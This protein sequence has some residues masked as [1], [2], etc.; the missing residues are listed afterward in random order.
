MTSGAGSLGDI[1]MLELF[2]AE[3]ETHAACL[4]TG[5][6][7][8]EGTGQVPELITEMMRSA[9]SI[10][11]AA[12]IVGIDAAVR[13]A[14]AMED[15]FV[16]VGQGQTTLKRQGIDILLECVDLLKQL[17]QS[18]PQAPSSHGPSIDRLTSALRALLQEAPASAPLAPAEVS[19]QAAPVPAAPRPPAHHAN[20]DEKQRVVR[21]S[22]GH[23]E[24]LTSL[25]GESLVQTR[26]LRSFADSLLSLQLERHQLAATLAHLQENLADRCD[27]SSTQ[28]LDQAQQ[29]TARLGERMAQQVQDFDLAQRRLSSTTE[30]LYREALASR[31]RPFSDGVQG[32]PRMVRDLAHSL[33]KEV[34]LEILGQRTPV[35]RD[36]LDRLE[37]PLTH[38][39][40]NA[41][42]H[43]LEPTAER[44]SE[45]K[46]TKGKIRLE[47]RHIGGVLSIVISDDGRGIDLAEVRRRIKAKGLADQAMIDRMT[48]GELIEFLFLPGFST[49]DQVTELSGRGVGLD[50]LRAMLREVGGTVRIETTPGH[51]TRFELRLPLTLSVMR[52]L[53][54]EVAGEPYAL[55]LRH[56]YRCLRIP[57]ADVK[58]VEDS[59]YITVDDENIGLITMGQVLELV[60]EKTEDFQDLAI[61]ITGERAHRFAF[62]LD[63]F[64]G[65]RDLVVRPLDRRLGR[66]PDVSAASIM[67]DGTP[68]LILDVEDLI[69]SAEALLA[70]GRLS[71]A[72][73]QQAQANP[74]A[75]QRIL[76]VDD[77][78]TVREVE[79]RLLE[80]HGYEVEV[81]V[82]GA[83]GWRAIR[84]TPY[85]LL[86]T[87]IDMPVLNGIEL[88]RLVRGD[89]TLKDLPIMIVSYQDSPSDRQRGLEAGA[90]YY[91]TKS[92]F[93]DQRLI[94][95]VIDLIGEARK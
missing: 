21:V 39:V 12:R 49:R 5:L 62:Q 71:S 42:D 73:H 47:A 31:M 40:R 74:Q 24:H 70:E 16:A 11:G 83:D 32:F 36:V 51:G 75:T 52:C 79:R 84:A 78:I 35:D 14:H 55:A 54:F 9:H 94:D 88:V 81:A 85:D 38:L 90:S 15:C 76:V 87:D 37:A 58:H 1:S 27:A 66:T 10:K 80:S 26:W 91:L 61:I 29:W 7:H 19:L 23:M 28:L 86:I 57:R 44:L 67:E 56:V 48:T 3:V 77:S 2:R 6:L 69:H 64:L 22:V 63:R 59:A 25:A 82:N 13:V 20:S 93:H 60:S 33:G 72:D 41:V 92:S 50:V 45:G 89:Q 46:V 68:L 4:S 34:E 53:L 18:D 8:L 65:E 30:R 43:G 95:A 17:A